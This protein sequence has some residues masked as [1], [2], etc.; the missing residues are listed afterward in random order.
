MNDIATRAMFA[1]SGVRDDAEDVLPKEI[2]RDQWG[3]P[4]IMNPDGKIYPYVRASTL[5]KALD[6]TEALGMW[7]ARMA[8]RGVAIVPALASAFA[9]FVDMDD[10]ATKKEAN[11]LVEQAME[12]AGAND[13]RT[14]GTGIHGLI[15]HY[16]TGHA[17]PHVPDHLRATLQSFIRATSSWRFLASELFVV[18]HR[19]RSAGSA[20]GVALI[21]GT[22]KPRIVDV[23]TGKVADYKAVSFGIQLAVYAFAELYNP[24]T[25][26][27][28]PFPQAMDLEVVHIIHVD[29]VKERTHIYDVDLTE[30]AKAADLAVAVRAMRS[31]AKN[32]MVPTVGGVPKTVMQQLSAVTS[33]DEL[34]ALYASTGQSWG[35]KEKRFADQIAKGLQG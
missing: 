13:T 1:N 9:G 31:N 14:Q 6:E 18:N 12:R 3:R 20:D 24:S 11:Q 26:Q 2:T 17:I 32:I 15:E 19:W 34:H 25:G 10:P 33:F 35:E 16:I 23:K 22:T 29:P 21:P 30:G 4:M 7:K 8:A 28:A 27:T 5:A